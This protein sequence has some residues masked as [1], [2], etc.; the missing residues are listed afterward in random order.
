MK[1]KVTE[2]LAAGVPIV[3]T[4]FGVQ[5]MPIMNGVH[6]VVAD[7]AESFA[8]AMVRLFNEPETAETI[9]RA[10]QALAGRFSPEQ[11]ERL[12]SRCAIQLSPGA[13]GFVVASR[14][15]LRNSTSPARL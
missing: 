15:R 5:G 11:V 14:G 8:Q 13:A 1:I 4:R 7:D 10:G 2:A 12:I 6:A 3:S 9:S